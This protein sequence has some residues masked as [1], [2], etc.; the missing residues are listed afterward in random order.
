MIGDLLE[1]DGNIISKQNLVNKTG[2]PVLNDLH[3]LS[4]KMST[5]KLINRYN[6]EP[7]HPQKPQAPEYH[8]FTTKNQKGSKQFYNILI[9]PTETITKINWNENLG[10]NITIPQWNQIYKTC[11]HT[12]KNN[13]LIWLQFKIINLRNETTTPKNENHL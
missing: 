13:Y 8:S 3:Y 10:I 11:F 7:I 9:Q 12:I 2:L 1:N 4:L 6:F 5:Q